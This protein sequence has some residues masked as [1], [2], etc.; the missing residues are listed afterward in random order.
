[1]VRRRGVRPLVLS[2]LFVLGAWLVAGRPPIWHQP[3]PPRAGLTELRGVD[4]LRARFNAD[5]GK[6]RL[7]LVLSPT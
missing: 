6:T 7:I 2:L 4:E 3:D 5:A 1:M